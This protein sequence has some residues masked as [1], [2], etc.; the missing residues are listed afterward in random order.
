MRNRNL[1]I[2]LGF[3]VTIITSACASTPTPNTETTVQAAL[4]VTQAEQPTATLEPTAMLE[5]TTPKP[6][7][8]PTETSA[9]TVT[10]TQTPEPTATIPQPTSTPDTQLLEAATLYSADFENGYPF[11]LF[12]WSQKWNLKEENDG[13]TIFCNEIDD[14][15]SGFQFGS[16]EWA[17]YALSLRVKFLSDNEEQSAETYIRINQASEGYRASIWQNEW[18]GIAFYSPYSDLGGVPVDI[19]LDKWYQIELRF[20]EN[21]LSYYFDDELLVEIS[22][23]KRTSGRAGFGA[24]PNTEVCVDD[25]LVLGLD[26]SGDPIESPTGLAQDLQSIYEGECVF[27][28]INGS[29]PSMPIW[30]AAS[31]GYTHRPDDPREQIVIDEK[32]SV[33]ANDEVHFENQIV[34]VRPT[35]RQDIE[36]YGRLVIKEIV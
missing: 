23:D 8:T 20:V 35:K 17:N 34:W 1:L 5:P 11:G 22:D 30:D 27:C 13:N 2:A 36:V 15:W 12:D 25:I 32:F 26:E 9:P 29:D 14:Q 10:P 4:A 7:T 3:M 21:D 19:D 28:F 24:A 33:A 18:S 31:Q 6:T 16:D